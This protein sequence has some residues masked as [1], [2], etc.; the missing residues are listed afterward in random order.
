MRVQAFGRTFDLEL[1]DNA[2]LLHAASAQ[3]LERIGDVQLLKGAI[4]RMRS[5]GYRIPKAAC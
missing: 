4:K 2:R 5:F 3:L 1:A